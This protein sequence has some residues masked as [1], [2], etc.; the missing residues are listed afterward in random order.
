MGLRIHAA[1][2]R[3]LHRTVGLELKAKVSDWVTL[4]GRAELEEPVSPG[5]DLEGDQAGGTRSL[6]WPWSA[7]GSY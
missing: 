1:K 3:F 4:L 5:V 7:S 6:G 2:I